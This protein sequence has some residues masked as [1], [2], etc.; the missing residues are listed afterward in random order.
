MKTIFIM[1]LLSFV[2]ISG[3]CGVFTVNES[4]SGHVYNPSY[5]QC[6]F[7]NVIYATASSVTISNSIFDPS[8]N[9]TV[10]QNTGTIPFTVEGIALWEL[11]VVSIDGAEIT[12]YT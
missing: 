9:A 7:F 6:E 8:I 1:S 2:F 5:D 10:I 12:D 3:L 11:F 4:P